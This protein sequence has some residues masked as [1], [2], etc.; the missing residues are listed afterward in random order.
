MRVGS[1]VILNVHSHFTNGI[2]DVIGIPF[3]EVGI[4]LDYKCGV[5]TVMF[6]MLNSKIT[7][8]EEQD[9]EIISEVK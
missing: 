3:N 6:P 7:S 2:K 1:L 9:L 8:L 4:V 5:C